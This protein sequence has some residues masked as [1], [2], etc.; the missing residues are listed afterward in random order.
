M[1]G[2]KI[3]GVLVLLVPLVNVS[4][5]FLGASS[6]SAGKKYVDAVNWE[7]NR[8]ATESATDI[9]SECKSEFLKSVTSSFPD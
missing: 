3:A 4:S 7:A 9:V 5:L 6:R 2:K 1:A 8:F